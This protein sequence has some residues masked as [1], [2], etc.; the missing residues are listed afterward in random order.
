MFQLRQEHLDAFGRVA[1]RAWHLHV[2]D[3][4]R[5]IFPDETKGLSDEQLLKRVAK[6]HRAANNLGVHSRRGVMRVVGFDFLAGEGVVDSPKF[7]AIFQRP[8][9]DPEILIEDMGAAL[10]AAIRGK[11]AAGSPRG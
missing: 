10:P 2:S 8:D 1:Q 11:A 5:R 7:V 6:G 4:M 9:V 3:K